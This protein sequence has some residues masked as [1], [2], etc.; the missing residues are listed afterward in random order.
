MVAPASGQL[1]GAVGVRPGPRRPDAARVDTTQ[2]ARLM[3][4][5][6]IRKLRA[7]N[8]YD[9][10]AARLLDCAAVHVEKGLDAEHERA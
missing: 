2:A 9:L 1:L 5:A 8:E 4:Q 7:S 3:D 10:M 6:T